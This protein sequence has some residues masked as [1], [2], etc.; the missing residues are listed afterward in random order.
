MRVSRIVVDWILK[1]GYSA[2]N[3]V[4]ELIEKLNSRPF[5]KR[6]LKREEIQQEIVQCDALLTDALSL[7]SVRESTM[8]PEQSING[9]FSHRFLF[10]SAP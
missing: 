5:L 8:A 1:I 6:Y 9:E 3:D 2:F 4:L 7:F 10:R